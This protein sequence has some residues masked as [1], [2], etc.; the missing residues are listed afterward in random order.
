MV[1]LSR[2][3]PVHI[4]FGPERMAICLSGLQF[5]Y[6]RLAIYTVFNA[7]IDA[8]VL[9]GIEKIITFVLGVLHSECVAN[10]FSLRVHL[11][12]E[13]PATHGIQEVEADREF[14]P[15]PCVNAVT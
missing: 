1:V 12:R 8:P 9:I 3:K 6:H 10:V 11:K 13:I 4:R 15:K 7:E 2:R 5:L 14:S